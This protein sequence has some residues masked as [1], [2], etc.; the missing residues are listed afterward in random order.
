MIRGVKDLLTTP[1]A[2]DRVRRK[3]AGRQASSE[4]D[5]TVAG[6]L[7]LIGGARNHGRARARE[8]GGTTRPLLWVSKS[9]EKLATALRGLNHSVC[10]TRFVPTGPARSDPPWVFPPGQSQEER[11]QPAP[12]RDGQFQHI[13]RQVVAL[14]AAG[15]PVVSVDTKKKELVRQRAA[16]GEDPLGPGP[17]S[18]GR[19]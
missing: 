15:Q 17:R 10:A 9:R 19:A 5:P 14:Q 8:R 18:I 11:G 1:A 12:D 16:A 13:N 7:A 2:S 4:A 3:G 6:R